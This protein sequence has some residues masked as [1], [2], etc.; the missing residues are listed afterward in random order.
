[1]NKLFFFLLFQTLMNITV[2]GPENCK[3][4]LLCW[5]DG[6]N[7][8][9]LKNV[10]KTYNIK[11]CKSVV[12]VLFYHRCD[13]EQLSIDTKQTKRCGVCKECTKSTK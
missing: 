11:K 10:S 2:P 13:L 1:M 3:S 6:N 12:L 5:V 8:I 9:I 7:T 4:P